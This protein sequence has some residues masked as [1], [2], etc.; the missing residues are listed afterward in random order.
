MRFDQQS[1]REA[2]RRAYAAL[3]SPKMAE[4]ERTISGSGSD[5]QISSRK[6]VKDNPHYVP[7]K[8]T[9]SPG[10]LIQELAWTTTTT[11]FNF[12]FSINGP[13]LIAG[14]NNNSKIGKNDIFA[15]YGMQILLATG[16]NPA[17]FIYRSHGVLATDNA[18]YNSTI[19]IKTEAST[20]IDKIEGQ[21]FREM[22][23]N[24]NEFYGEM[25]MQ[26]VNPIRIVSGELG[27][28]EVRV[29]IKNSTAALVISTNTL[30][31][32]RLHGVYGQAQ[33]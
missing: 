6:I 10:M 26:L 18:V 33:G 8:L 32:M 25:G 3:T 23:T 14:T 31:S 30:I 28:F 13:G 15:V 29:Q 17:S 4:I 16:T 2:Q 11:T 1:I 7:A 20:Y 21:Y 9:T 12:D 24:A 5:K 19:S 22:G 27:V